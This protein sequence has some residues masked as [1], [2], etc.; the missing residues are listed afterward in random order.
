[1]S[2]QSITDL[3]SVKTVE[4]EDVS[5]DNRYSLNIQVDIETILAEKDDARVSEKLGQTEINLIR[6]LMV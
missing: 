2:E 3:D 4:I 1:M 6:S 5:I